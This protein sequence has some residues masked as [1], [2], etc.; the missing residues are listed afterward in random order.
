MSAKVSSA[1]F[2][3]TSVGD[4]RKED[5][6]HDSLLGAPVFDS[7]CCGRDRVTEETNVPVPFSDPIQRVSAMMMSTPGS[8]LTPF[9]RHIDR[10]CATMKS[11]SLQS[12]ATIARGLVGDA[13]Y[14]QQE[15]CFMKEV[16]G[17]PLHPSRIL[18]IPDGHR[19][20]AHKTGISYQD[21][22]HLGALVAAQVASEVAA[23][24][25][26]PHLTLFPLATKN[27]DD[28]DQRNLMVI[29]TAIDDF[30]DAIAASSQRMRLSVRGSLR[31]L[32]TPLAERLITM[33]SAI[34]EAADG[35]MDL[36]LL[37]DYDGQA[38]F[39][40][41]PRDQIFAALANPYD[42]V[43]RTG[44]AFRLSGAPLIESSAADMFAL[45]MTFPEFR[46]KD[47]VDVV[48]RFVSDKER[49]VLLRR[50]CQPEDH[51]DTR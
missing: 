35:S 44:G 43:I 19:R 47:I 10:T 2:L 33:T 12:S 48:H 9:I 15:Y 41:M 50:D 13:S 1:P 26:V 38:E 17:R 20:Y 5:A 14:R 32:P 18:V 3:G 4:Q 40:S 28:R 7:S 23:T 37:V 25:L 6:S 24:H 45:P 51:E 31:R 27:F 8:K 16:E 29:F 11:T 39:A 36:Q 42:I 22:Y 30:L 46:Y 34:A 21:A 49:R